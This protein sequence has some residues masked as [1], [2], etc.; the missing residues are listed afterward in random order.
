MNRGLSA[1]R[2]GA[3]AA[4]V[5][6]ITA[7]VVAALP[8]SASAQSDGD[9]YSS[10]A[11]TVKWAGGNA[12]DV[13]KYQP[14]HAVLTSDGQGNDAGSGHWD[15]FK[16]LEVTVSKTK[17]L[18][19]ESVLITAKGMAPTG[20]APWGTDFTNFL[21]A[22]QCWGPD[23][24]AADFNETC[25]FGGYSDSSRADGSVSSYGRLF[26][27]SAAVGTTLSRW[28]GADIPFRTVSGQVSAPEPVGIGGNIADG[29]AR[30]FARENTNEL[31]F[32]PIDANGT[33]REPFTVQSAPTQPY[34]GCGNRSS[35][36]GGRCW[37]VIVPRGAHA[38]APAGGDAAPCNGFGSGEHG[39]RVQ[40]S[41]GSPLSPKCTAW[42]D[43]IAVPLD[44]SDPYQTCPANVA[45]RRVVGSQLLSQAFSSWQGK[46]CGGSGASNL[47]LTTNAPDLTRGQLLTGQVG[48]AAVASAITPASIGSADPALLA[49]ADLAYAPLANTALAIA[50]VIEDDESGERGTVRTQIRLT[51]RLIAKLLTQSY[52]MDIPKLVSTWSDTGVSRAA[53][54]RTGNAAAVYDDPEWEAL[55]N[56]SAATNAWGTWLVWG[57]QGDDAIELLWRYVQADA[58]A[59]AFLRGKPD[60]WG[61]VVNP[62]YEY[63]PTGTNGS[64]TDLSTTPLSSFVKADRTTTPSTAEDL[65]TTQGKFVDSTAYSPYSESPL[66]NA[67]RIATADTKRTAE[68]S[69]A[70]GNF[71]VDEKRP[72][73]TN[74]GRFALGPTG[75]SAAA[76]YNLATASIALPLSSATGTE[77]VATARSFVAPTDEAVSTALAAAPVDAATGVATVDPKTTPTGGYPLA[78]TINGAVNL[79]ALDA[80]S[81]SDYARLLE[82]A[83][84]DGNVPGPARGQLPEGYVPLTTSQAA[85]TQALAER[86]RLPVSGTTTTPHPAP[87]KGAPAAPIAAA[88]APA[89]PVAANTQTGVSATP[90]LAASTTPGAPPNVTQAALGAGLLAG[91]AGAGA[92]AVLLRRRRL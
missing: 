60:P 81:R 56:P 15:D 76:T 18:G 7:S 71:I 47:A 66:A 12:S 91:L 42:Q 37:L 65:K 54:T 44:F 82:Y 4:A 49:S 1:R 29:T 45:E 51:P 55:G 73:M 17:E 9:A 80:T 58:D 33:S 25:E 79:T 87:A 6:A 34:L 19:D 57:P 35:T 69:G 41:L 59:I 31:P 83:A 50:F 36:T 74:G 92:G 72:R 61:Q 11:I 13:Q 64:T 39:T 16:N 40:A 28:S 5:V 53:L 32:I 85:V 88:A 8:T 30:F 43:R 52:L 90:A 78:M 48:M 70:V 68:W 46:L 20:I 26:N 23:P 10:S 77:D 63:D 22:F 62:Y 38:N 27:G 2:R 3:A 67:A 84:G 14:D 21:Q 89:A 86:L 75:L 24:T